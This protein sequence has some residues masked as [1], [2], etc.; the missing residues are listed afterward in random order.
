[1]AYLDRISNGIVCAR[2][3]TLRLLGFP[4]GIPSRTGRTKLNIGIVD[5]LPDV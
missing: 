5:T 1:M 3:R 2:R 4:P